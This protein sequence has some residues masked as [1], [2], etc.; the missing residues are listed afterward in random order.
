M[1][2]YGILPVSKVFF[3]NYFSKESFQTFEN[4][5]Y[6][7]ETVKTDAI[8][9]F[10]SINEAYLTLNCSNKQE[11][12]ELLLPTKKI[13][14][15]DYTN[16]DDWNKIT[17]MPNEDL[18]LLGYIAV[19]RVKQEEKERKE[20]SAFLLE[21]ADKKEH[22]NFNIDDYPEK[23]KR[24]MNSFLKKFNSTISIKLF[25][26]FWN[27]DV[28]DLK[29][30]A[31]RVSPTQKDLEAI[32]KTQNTAYHNLSNYLAA[33]YMDVYV[34]TS[35]RNDPDYFSVNQFV[36]DLFCRHEL[37]Q[38]KL[39]YF[40][41]TQSWI[42]DRV[43]KG[44]VEALMLRR[45][46]I[47]IYMAQKGDTFGKDSEASVTLGQGKSVIVYVPKLFD[48]NLIIDSEKTGQLKR[49]DLIYELSALGVNP[50]DI[51]AQESNADIHA[52]LIKKKLELATD[53]D[54]VRIIKNHWADFDIQG[55]IEVQ[56]H[57]GQHEQSRIALKRW[58]Q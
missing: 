26:S 28:E 2:Y 13:N 5:K 12:D 35:M 56:L 40:N 19:E 33:D 16:R 21:I 3:E 37:R 54:Y 7:I 48:K 29:T 14:T 52:R 39:R 4:F 43:A 47:C 49:D 38:L 10:S 8:R 45:A 9:L 36:E 42:A 58:V 27:P 51:D 6:D 23:K 22:N 25:N 31:K 17:Q 57:E 20:L 15:D 41:P 53:E 34:A 11:F 1:V 24:K 30:E 46:K 18:P 50:K 55:E 32:E 44:L